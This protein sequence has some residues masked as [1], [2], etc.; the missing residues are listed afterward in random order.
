[1]RQSLVD[2]KKKA[3]QALRQASNPTALE[4]AYKKYFGRAAG[5]LTIE[6][7][8]LKDLPLAEKK[9]IGPL[10]QEVKT[11]LEAL[12]TQR[13]AA[14]DSS[15]H[16][17]PS[18]FDRTLPGGLFSRGHLHPL[19]QFT[20]RLEEIFLSMG[21]EIIAGRE[22]ES[23]HY[24][25]DLLNIPA[26]HPARDAHDTFWVKQNNH[27]AVLRTHTSPMQIRAMET[28]QPPVRLIVPG[29]VFRHEATDASHEATF[30][31]CEGLV[32]DENISLRD[33]MGTLRDVLSALFEKEVQI[34]IRPSFFPFV[35]PGVEADMA[36]LLCGGRGC[37]VCKQKGWVEMLGA[38]LVHPKVLENMSINPSKYSG[39]AFGI[40]VDRLAMAYYGIN[41]IRLMHSG[42]LRFIKQF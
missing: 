16:S 26:D 13:L 28:R 35:E 40:G 15:G 34:R 23:E 11:S 20:H 8:K 19:T 18:D 14:L 36:C 42:D 2:I 25:F 21:F 22:V 1:M 7:K 31:Q 5:L 30:Y 9:I 6:L 41:D 29:K 27:S 3:S 38:G 37:P 39:F 24:N 10:A 32:I 12:Y 33:L 17:L 4:K